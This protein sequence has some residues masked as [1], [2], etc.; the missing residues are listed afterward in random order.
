MEN[1]SLVGLR[2]NQIV[3][4]LAQKGAFQITSYN[5]PIAVVIEPPKSKRQLYAIME[6][7]ARELFDE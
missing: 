7:L 4:K 2:S 5:K 3:R 1:L 6:K